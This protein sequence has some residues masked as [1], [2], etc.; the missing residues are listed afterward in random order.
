[1]NQYLNCGKQ[2]EILNRSQGA[3]CTDLVIAFNGRHDSGTKTSGNAD[4]ES[5]NH[6]TNE[7]IPDHVL[8]PPSLRFEV[9]QAIHGGGLKFSCSYLGAAKNT[10]TTEAIIMTLPHTTN[11][12][13]RNNF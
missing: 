7:D 8:L 12:T 9:S 5:S 10:M 1:M 4:T 2:S 6:T 3:R 11:P 13:A